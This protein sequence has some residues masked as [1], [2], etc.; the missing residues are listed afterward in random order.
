MLLKRTVAGAAIIALG[1][2][3]IASLSSITLAIAAIAVD[4][5]APTDFPIGGAIGTIVLIAW[6]PI[7]SQSLRGRWRSG[8]RAPTP[9]AGE[10]AARWC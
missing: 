2:L 5:S 4:L 8:E 7:A 6:T 10:V 3:L 9:R 1:L